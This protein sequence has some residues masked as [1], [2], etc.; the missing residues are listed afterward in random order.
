[1]MA[2]LNGNEGKP[3]AITVYGGTFVG[4]NPAN[5]DANDSNGDRKNVT[6]NYYKENM[7]LEG[8]EEPGIVPDGYTIIEETPTYGEDTRTYYIVEY[9]K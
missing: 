3:G 6:E 7:F 5:G 1:M 2:I 4:A 8:Q 9:N